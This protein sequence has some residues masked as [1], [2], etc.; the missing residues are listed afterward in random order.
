MCISLGNGIICVAIFLIVGDDEVLNLKEADSVRS[1]D[2][3]SS[4]RSSYPAPLVTRNLLFRYLA[5][6]GF[7]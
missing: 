2:L 3:I 6:G 7:W 4:L 1:E 5:S